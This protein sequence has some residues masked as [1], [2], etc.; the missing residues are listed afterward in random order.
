MTQDVKS[1]SFETRFIA[2]LEISLGSMKGS[3][4]ELRKASEDMKS[5]Q[6]FLVASQERMST[7]ISEMWAFMKQYGSVHGRK[8]DLEGRVAEAIVGK[9]QR[10]NM[11]VV[12][13]LT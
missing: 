12:N 4:E 2:E 1:I 7:M 10:G 6:D 13:H 5:T 9:G 11:G 8:F 3:H